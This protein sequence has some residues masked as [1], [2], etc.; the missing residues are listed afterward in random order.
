M[1]KVDIEFSYRMACSHIK[2]FF[3]SL[4]NVERAIREF[5]DEA[6]TDKIKSNWEHSMI[7]NFNMLNMHLDYLNK[8]LNL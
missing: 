3:Q 7:G 5:D 8:S 1:G 4:E 2:Y 6:L